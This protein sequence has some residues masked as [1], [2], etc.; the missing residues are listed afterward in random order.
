MARSKLFD[1][2]DN[3]FLNDV[4]FVK[5]CAIVCAGLHVL[6]TLKSTA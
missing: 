4:K 3:T 5:L 6:K 2:C 1:N